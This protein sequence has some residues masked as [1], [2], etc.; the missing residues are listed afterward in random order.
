MTK[1][2][3]FT[4]S[5]SAIICEVYEIE[6]DTLEEANE[7]LHDGNYGEPVHTE[8]LDWHGNWEEDDREII[9]PLYRMVKD[10]N[11]VDPK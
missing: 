10:Y 3:K 11:L 2:Y 7:M 1:K 6:A 9:D 8:W 4:M 5:R